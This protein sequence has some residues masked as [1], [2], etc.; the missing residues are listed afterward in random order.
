LCGVGLSFAEESVRMRRNNAPHLKYLRFDDIA[1]VLGKKITELA[2]KPKP[3][4]G[5]KGALGHTR[6]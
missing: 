1:Q 2:Q 6:I 5:R 3:P 4:S